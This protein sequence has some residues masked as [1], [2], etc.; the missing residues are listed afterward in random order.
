[1]NKWIKAASLGLILSTTSIAANAAQ[2]V[3]YVIIQAAMQEVAQTADING[4]LQAEFKDR[5]GELQ[6]LEGQAKPKL[7][8][9]Q[10]DGELMTAAERSA[11]ENEVR[12]IE[13]IYTEKAQQLSQD[14]QR[15]GMEE[16]QKMAMKVRQAIA[17]VAE[18]EGYD[19]VVDASAVLFADPAH[20]LSEK[21]IKAL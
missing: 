8:K 12:G 9:L 4:K 10:R 15:R 21:V 14:Q 3:G 11:L 5:I 16:E 18:A 1:M 13:K 17:K 19:I 20:D 7:E 2:K 6:A